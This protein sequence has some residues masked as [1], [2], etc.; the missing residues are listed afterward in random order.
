MWIQVI[1][2]SFILAWG[3]PFIFLLDWSTSKGLS[4]FVFSGNVLNYPLFWRIVL[5]YIEFLVDCYFPLAL[6]KCH[7]L[8]FWSIRVL[9]WNQLVVLLRI[10]VAKGTAYCCFQDS[11]FGSWQLDYEV[12]HCGHLPVYL[13]RGLP[14]SLD[15]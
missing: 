3:I 12:F 13:T 14:N 4:V 11:V 10:S 1:V 2:S 5:K 15:T 7:P 6:W 8:A 9:V